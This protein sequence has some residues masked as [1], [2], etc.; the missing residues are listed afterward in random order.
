[1]ETIN[2]PGI[3][4]NDYSLEIIKRNNQVV[5]IKKYYSVINDVTIYIYN[6]QIDAVI[7]ALQKLKNKE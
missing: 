1:M 2:I 4:D 7:A 5:A 3:E 6:E